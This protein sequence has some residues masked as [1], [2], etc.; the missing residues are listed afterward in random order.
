MILDTLLKRNK[1]KISVLVY[2]K[3]THTTALTTNQVTRKA[4]F[5]S[6]LIKYILLSPIKMT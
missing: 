5:R 4:S 3:Y 6:C 2:G 1:G